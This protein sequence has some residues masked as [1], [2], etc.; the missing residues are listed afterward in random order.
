MAPGSKLVNIFSYIIGTVG[1]ERKLIV[2][3]QDKNT[4]PMWIYV[5]FFNQRY[6]VKFMHEY[7][8]TQDTDYKNIENVDP[9][10]LIKFG[11]KDQNKLKDVE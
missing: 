7:L 3:Q 10:P 8:I 6:N 4:K 1:N 2:W 11:K 9:K 5:F